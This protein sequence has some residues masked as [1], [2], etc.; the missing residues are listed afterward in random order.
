[1][2]DSYKIIGRI[3]GYAFLRKEGTGKNEYTEVHPVVPLSGVSEVVFLAMRGITEGVRK[4]LID[5]CLSEDS[6]ENRCSNVSDNEATSP[7]VHQSL[8]I[9]ARLDDCFFTGLF[10][11]SSELAPVAEDFLN[12][13]K[14]INEYDPF[15]ARVYIKSATKIIKEIESRDT[16]EI[17]V[18]IIG[19]LKNLQDSLMEEIKGNFEMAIGD[20]SLASTTVDGMR[21]QDP[22][23]VVFLMLLKEL[24]NT[25]MI[26]LVAQMIS[27]ED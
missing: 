27:E 23:F 8:H 22:V 19:A 24:I 6:E 20:G 10:Y 9:A 25:T 26:R 16:R 18:R 2:R 12:I 3:P 15:V 11:S 21:V 7:R 4:Q 5:I 13:L 14:A 17:L 1:M